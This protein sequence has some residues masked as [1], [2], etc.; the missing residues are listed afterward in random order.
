MFMSGNNSVESLRL[1]VPQ[2]SGLVDIFANES[3]TTTTEV[4]V[5]N[6]PDSVQHEKVVETPLAQGL[7]IGGLAVFV[8]AIV[9]LNSKGSRY[10]SSQQPTSQL[11]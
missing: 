7:A 11:R 1:F 10:T 4:Q 5:P 2:E 6:S 8:G 9:L 3:A